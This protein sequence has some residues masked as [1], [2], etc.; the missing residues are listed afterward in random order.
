MNTT[1]LVIAGTIAVGVL[2]VLPIVL[3]VRAARSK[4]RSPHWMW[5]GF[6][7]LLA[8]I[9]YLVIRSLPTLRTCAHCFEK[10]NIEA[11]VCPHCTRSFEPESPAGTRKKS[12]KKRL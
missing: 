11:R 7:P 2:W 8:W 3:G 10:A 5:F 9:P 4:N 6:Y 12:Q 1:L